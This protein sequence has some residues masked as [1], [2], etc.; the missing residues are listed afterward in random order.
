MDYFKVIKR[1]AQITWTYKST[2]L[3]GILISFF[4]GGGSSPNYNVGSSDFDYGK[5]TGDS[6]G[7][8]E[9]LLNPIV[10]LAVVI[11]VLIVAALSI[12]IG[13]LARAALIGMVEDVE[14]EGNTSVNK[15]FSYG[16]S[17]WL[18]L[19]GINISIWFPFVICT[20]IVAFLLLS[21]AIASFVFEQQVLAVVLLIIGILLLLVL[22]VPTIIGLSVIELL[23]QRYRIIGKMGVFGSISEGYRIMRARLGEV[24]VFWL[25][26]LLIGMALGIVLIPVTLLLLAPALAFAFV[27]VLLAIAIGLPGIMVLIFFGGLVQAFTSAAWTEFFMELTQEKPVLGDQELSSS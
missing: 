7:F 25:I 20:I 27:N 5:I 14:V 6:A 18:P 9:K 16:W 1:A 3:F 11:I 10:I 8:I 26:M 21:P 22:L 19:F 24:F 13:F 23:S 4:Q 15:G 17:N 12:V 2:W